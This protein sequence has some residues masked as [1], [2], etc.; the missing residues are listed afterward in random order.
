M[1]VLSK[2]RNL[3]NQH[4]HLQ[5]EQKT[6]DAGYVVLPPHELQAFLGRRSFEHIQDDGNDNGNVAI[7]VPLTE[8]L[9][10]QNRETD[11]LSAQI[12]DQCH[13]EED[14]GRVDGLGR[15]SRKDLLTVEVLVSDDPFTFNF[16]VKI[17]PLSRLGVLRRST[18]VT[19]EKAAVH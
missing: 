17:P 18:E 8:I 12:D 16:L 1:D 15:K 3:A 6:G 13:H 9:V 11:C 7:S 2:F 4:Q 19:K 10:L 5:P 14:P